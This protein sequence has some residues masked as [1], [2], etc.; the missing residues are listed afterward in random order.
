MPEHELFILAEL[1]LNDNKSFMRLP[2]LVLSLGVLTVF[3]AGCTHKYPVVGAFDDHNE[4]YLGTVLHN[5]ANGTA[6][7]EVESEKSG[8]K[9]RGNSRITYMP[10]FSMG[11]GQKGEANLTFDDGRTVI[12]YWTTK[13]LTTGYG[14]GHDQFG[15]T[16][17]FTFGMSEEEAAEYVTAL[18]REKVNLPDLPPPYRPKET[19]EE[20]GYSTGSG[21][22]V[23]DEGHVITN[24]HVIEDAKEIK[25]ITKSGET[26]DAQVLKRDPANDVAL[27]QIQGTSKGLTLSDEIVKGESVLTIG[28][29][30]VAVQGQES[31]VTLGHVNALSGVKGDVRFVQI[32]VPIQP[33]NSGGPLFN[34][35]GEVIGV[36]TA[37]LN[38]IQTLRES[39]NL[40]QNV[41]YAVKSDYVLPLLRKVPELE[42]RRGDYS[43]SRS[44]LIAEVD[45]SVVL[46]IAE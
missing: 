17:Q 42:E 40:P 30:L 35:K 29:P 43:P 19:R 37:T 12:A 16:F 44:E 20:V 38:V 36:V 24:F 27:L 23:S 28:Y 11:G 8:V 46:V 32:D 21:F 15:N 18:K 45:R 14:S 9:G 33:G 41:N 26:L 10:A 1:F 4:V 31:K 2:K 6:Y 25:V 39:G 3:L 34:E 7:I 22:F 13:T 5:S